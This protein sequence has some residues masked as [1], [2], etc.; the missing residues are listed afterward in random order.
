VKKVVKKNKSFF[1]AMLFVCLAS[2]L[3]SVSFASAKIL[4]GTVLIKDKTLN[5][6][7]YFQFNLTPAVRS[8]GHFQLDNI[9]YQGR[10]ISRG[11]TSLVNLRFFSPDTN[12]QQFNNS[13][14]R[15]PKATY[16][17][18]MG[19]NYS[20]GQDFVSTLS[21]QG[22]LNGTFFFPGDVIAFKITN[23]SGT[24]YGAIFVHN[25]K[26]NPGN[27]ITF[28]YSSCDLTFSEISRRCFGIVAT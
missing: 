17:D 13:F 5:S 11:N 10:I 24:Y 3:L 18:F 28:T 27:N 14:F 2:M 12:G 23:A 22:P 1:I 4:N 20:Y 6:S 19:K 25:F 9:S 8:S 26:M 15:V 7:Q 16:I 21:G